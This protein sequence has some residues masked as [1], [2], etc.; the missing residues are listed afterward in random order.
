[1]TLRTTYFKI[2]GLCILLTYN[3]CVFT[4]LTK[5]AVISLNNN[6]RLVF[7]IEAQFIFV[8]KN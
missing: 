6:D 2:T 3:I 4:I 7:V 8:K 5:T 1:M